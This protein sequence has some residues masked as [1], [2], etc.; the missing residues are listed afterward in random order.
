MSFVFSNIEMTTYWIDLVNMS[1]LHPKLW[2][3]GNP[4]EKK[5]KINYEGQFL[6]NSMFKDEIEKKI[7]K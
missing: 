2:D 3:H 4:I 7:L 1:N 6:I 5:I